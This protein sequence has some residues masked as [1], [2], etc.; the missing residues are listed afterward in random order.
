MT[1]KALRADPAAEDWW[2]SR[3]DTLIQQL[4]DALVIGNFPVA[5]ITGPPDSEKAKLAERFATVT[6]GHFPAG[7]LE[8]RLDEL[9]DSVRPEDWLPNNWV[10]FSKRGLVVLHDVDEGR[11]LRTAGRLVAEVARLV[12]P[13][14]VVTTSVNR[15]PLGEGMVR[16]IFVGVLSRGEVRELLFRRAGVD[17]SIAD[18]IFERLG[19]QAVATG[20][21]ADL[22]R[23]GFSPIAV[24]NG[25][26]PFSQSTILGPDGRPLARNERQYKALELA[27]RGMSDEVLSA[28]TDRPTFLHDLAPRRFEELIAELFARR[29]YEVE[30]TPATRDGGFDL[31]VRQHNELGSLLYLVECKRFAPDRP[32]GVALV[33]HLHGVVQAKQA[34]GGVLATTSRFTRGAREFERKVQHQIALRDY[35]DLHGWLLRTASHSRTRIYSY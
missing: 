4:A 26:E 15:L 31:Y 20:V 12:S 17:N 30:L 33:R 7:V 3:D 13:A 16:H 10:L 25:L 19:G 23:G 34:S 28:I 2:F 29:G 22:M 24:I 9:T 21:A 35:F 5:A 14:R 6:R 1:T 32:V 11:D 18:P 27:A 8:F